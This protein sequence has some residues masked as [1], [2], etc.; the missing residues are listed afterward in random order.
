MKHFS[1]FYVV[2][3]KYPNI[4][5]PIKLQNRNCWKKFPLYFEGYLELLLALF[6]NV[7][8]IYSTI[9]RGILFRNHLFKQYVSKVLDLTVISVLSLFGNVMW[10]LTKSQ[11]IK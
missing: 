3:F 10:M 11:K 6:Q 1:L 9:T 4:K 2:L 8:F 7:L 5:P